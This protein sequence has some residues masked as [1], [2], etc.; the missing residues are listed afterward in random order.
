MCEAEGC[1]QEVCIRK[2]MDEVTEVVCGVRVTSP[3]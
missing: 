1:V 3:D 2:S